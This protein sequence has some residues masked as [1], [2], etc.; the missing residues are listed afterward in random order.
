M[1]YRLKKEMPWTVLGPLEAVCMCVCGGG[2]GWM[3][4][5]LVSASSVA[6]SGVPHRKKLSVA[7]SNI[8]IYISSAN[9]SCFCCC[10]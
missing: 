1:Y 8:V 7:V 6:T 4:G 2:E 5:E 9:A 3:G 10:V